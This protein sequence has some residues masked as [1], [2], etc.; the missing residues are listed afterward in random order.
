[1]RF[2]WFLLIVLILSCSPFRF[3]KRQFVF[4]GANGDQAVA[5]RIPVGYTREE[6]KMDS[7]GNKEQFYYYRNGAFFYISRLEQPINPLQRIDQENNIPLEIPKGGL[8]FKGVLPGPLFW[9]EIRL[10]SF[11]IGYRNVPRASEIVFDSATNFAA[12]LRPVR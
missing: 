12:K 8:I 5:L 2:F 1:M 6:I 11:R 3:K 10:D 4:D 9:R 7:A